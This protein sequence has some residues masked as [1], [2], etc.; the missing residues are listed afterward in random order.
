MITTMNR[1][2]L[3]K[4]ILTVLLMTLLGFVL[5]CRFFTPL[6]DFYATHCYPLISRCLSFVSSGVP[7]SLEEIVV[8]GFALWL[9]VVL[10]RAVRRKK[11]FLWWIRRTVVALL[12]LYVWFYMGWMNNYFRT[13]LYARLDIQPA[14]YEEA[15]FS[16]FLADYTVL[17][18]GTA[19]SAPVWD[20]TQLEAEI[21]AFYASEIRAAGY[22]PLH[23]WQHAKK[24]LLNP[25]YSA[26][27]VLGFM[28]PCFSEA[29]LNR[30]LLP[31]EHP[32]TLAHELA[33][34][35]GVT[36]EAE[37]NYWAYAFCRQAAD[38]AVRYSGCLALL[39]Y[40][41][42]SARTF[43]SEDAYG[44]WVATLS[45]QVKE[46]DAAEAA[47]WEEK[48]VPVIDSFQHWLMDFS[49]RTNRVSEGARDYYGV[50]GIL[51]SM[52]AARSKL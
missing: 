45:E 20:R 25:L 29:Q 24:P 5:G 34:L 50:I 46:D 1:V 27:G 10:V 43:F 39:P 32:F 11:G 3:F 8:V 4:R 18:N 17:L 28:G 26:V 41:A 40:V 38:P 15:A 16:R 19:G 33:H 31:Y 9:I 22:V 48:R 37:A 21:K 14:S 51:M 30:D 52:D 42:S 35:S 36:S 49:L 2:L 12:W 6:A 23:P 7:F 13:P 47:Y 44:Q